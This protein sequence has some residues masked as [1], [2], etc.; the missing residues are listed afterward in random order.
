M[1]D[2]ILV[3]VSSNKRQPSIVRFA[4]TNRTAKLIPKLLSLCVHVNTQYTCTNILLFVHVTSV[5]L[6]LL[7]QALQGNCK[8][9][10]ALLAHRMASDFSVELSEILLHC[11]CLYEGS[12]VITDN[13]Y[14]SF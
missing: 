9:Y 13:Q 3:E 4:Y 1:I 8:D 11:F 6:Q 5:T 10:H 12:K 14:Y 2:S 7:V